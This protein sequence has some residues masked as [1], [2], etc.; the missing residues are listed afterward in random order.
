MLFLMR[1]H[2]DVM[3]AYA[4]HLLDTILEGLLKLPENRECADCKCKYVR[5]ATL[6]SWL[7]EQIA[8]IQSMGNQKYEDK[9]WVSKDNNTK[10]PARALE[11]KASVQ[12]QIPG[13]RSGHDHGPPKGPELVTPLPKAQQITEKK[14]EPIV[15]SS[16]STKQAI[17]CS[18]TVSAPKVDFAIDLFNM[19]SMDGPSVNGSE[20]A[21]A[22]DNAWVGSAAD[23]TG[24]TEPD[25][26]KTHSGIEDLFK[27]S[28]SVVSAVL[29]KP[30]YLVC[31]ANCYVAAVMGNMG[32]TLP[33]GTSVPFP[34]AWYFPLSFKGHIDGF[35]NQMFDESHALSRM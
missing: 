22:D 30:I 19:L 8:F 18:P 11:D 14:S 27:D 20:A 9:R 7:P 33:V 26:Q 2:A 12:R 16:K 35:I 29:E 34:T 23:K 10:S 13:D 24:S 25:A 5:F 6:D 15:A 32:L 28:P 31:F 4:Q 21:F 17:E 3:E 1:Y